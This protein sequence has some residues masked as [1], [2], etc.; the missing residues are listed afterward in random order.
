MFKYI[1]L[2][3]FAALLA[4]CPTTVDAQTYVKLWPNGLEG[5]IDANGEALTITNAREMGTLGVQIAGTWTGTIAP[6]CS[7]DGTNWVAIQVKPVNADTP[8]TSMSA[9]GIWTGSIAGCKQVRAVATASMTGT[10]SVTMNTIQGGGGSGSSAS[11]SLE[12]AELSVGAQPA[13]D[14]HFVRCS[15]GS[16]AAAC[17]VSVSALPNEGQQTMANSISVAIASNQSALTVGDGSGALNVIVDSGAVTVSD[18]SGALNT[19]V[20]SGTLTAVTTITNPV[21]VTDGSGALNAI[22]DSG[23]I[24]TITNAVTVTD[25]SGALNIICDSGCSGGTQYAEDAAHAS[26]NTGTLVLAVRS[27]NATQ[28]AGTDG[29]N[30]V[31]ITDASGRLHV[32]VGNTVTVS[33]GSGALNVICDSGCTGGGTQYAED[34]AHSSGNLGNLA[35]TVRQD[36]ATQ[37]AGTDGD[38]SVLITDSSGRL[39][40]NVGNTV[41]VGTHAVTDGGGSLTVDGTVTVTD[42][43]GALNVVIDSGTTAVTNAGTFAVQV[44]GSALTALQ[45]IDNI[46]SVEDAVAGN[47]FSGVAILAVRQD[48]QSD[49]CADGDFCPF[50]INGDGELR[51]TV[52]GGTGGTALAD[53]ATFTPG[54]TNITPIGGFFDDASTTACTENNACVARLT[55]NR[56]LHVSLRDTTGAAISVSTD[57]TED[58][59]HQNAVTGPA[60]MARRIDTAS[61]SAGTSGDYATINNDGLGRMWE[62]DGNPCG[63][64]ARISSA[65]ISTSS[66][67]NV[68][69]V[70]LNGS[71]LIYICGISISAGAATGVQLIYGTGTACAT[72]ETDLTGVYPFAANGGLV[73]VNGGRPQFVVPAGNAFCVENSGANAIAGHVT[74]VRTAAP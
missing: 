19:I 57:V 61:S 72:G 12:S 58:A 60:L 28:L 8:V 21:T 46:V 62:R 32:N 30:S 33:D 23:T 42:G 65:A 7:L 74:Y 48:S 51:V 11:V 69:I 55:E 14:P 45:L 22:I 68:E 9:N 40:V 73:M 1:R 43:S 10:A 59:A 2:L 34:A 20:D 29:D 18:G 31:L 16:A 17:D 54:T 64:H 27:D 24:T 36:T 38:N 5:E 15:N 67:G 25:G 63:D 44:D 13:D 41:T 6:Q 26:G 50:T 35:L 53:G 39:H 56:A 3:A 70:A 49:L 71:D 4:V 66:S 47:A 52:G 37:L